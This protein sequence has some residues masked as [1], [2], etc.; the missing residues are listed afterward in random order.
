MDIGRSTCAACILTYKVRYY[1]STG[2]RFKTDTGENY[3]GPNTSDP[4]INATVK[5]TIPEN[6]AY[7]D[8]FVVNNTSA[9]KFRIY[10]IY[11]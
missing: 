4:M 3:R 9:E 11:P 2:T 1:D 10:N 6:T 8:V 7:F 5:H